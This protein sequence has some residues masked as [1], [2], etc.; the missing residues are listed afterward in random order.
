[1][2]DPQGMVR[3]FHEKFGHPAPGEPTL[4]HFR[5]KLR[6][7]LIIEEAIEFVQAAG[8]EVTVT[9]NGNAYVVQ[10]YAP[11]WPEMID[12]LCDLTYVTMGAA[13]EMG[14]DL[15]PFFREVHR[16]NMDKTGGAT[17]ESGKTLK[18]EGWKPPRIVEMLRE[19]LASS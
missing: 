12:A 14:V 8:C 7:E 13:V 11:D 18:P 1:M 6:A 19:L 17:N 2:F 15:V 10:R 4:E 16:S 3:E 9:A 5:S